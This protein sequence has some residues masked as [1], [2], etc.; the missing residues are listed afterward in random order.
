MKFLIK[1]INKILKIDLK[2][3]E[4]VISENHTNINY[5][6]LLLSGVN[7]SKGKIFIGKKSIIEGS[8]ITETKQSRILIGN[9]TYIGRSSLISA[10]EI[11]VGDGVLIAWG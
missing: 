11:N 8:L 1:L 10:S 9:N 5:L 4:K 6:W 7:N 2:Y 3:T